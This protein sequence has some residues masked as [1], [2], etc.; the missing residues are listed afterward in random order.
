[1][2]LDLIG[3]LRRSLLLD[4]FILSIILSKQVQLFILLLLRLFLW[5]GFWLRIT[6]KVIEVGEIEPSIAGVFHLLIIVSKPSKTGEIVDLGLFARA[7]LLLFLGFGFGGGL[8][9][10]LKDRLWLRPLLFLLRLGVTH[11][12]FVKSVVKTSKNVDFWLVFTFASL[13]AHATDVYRHTLL[14]LIT[15]FLLLL[16]LLLVRIVVVGNLFVPKLLVHLFF[17][18]IQ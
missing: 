13:V 5:L 3:I 18:N 8:V 9:L 6:S 1:M 4:N 11:L 17:I 12:E 7:F 2:N 10:V 15:I 14:F 16:A